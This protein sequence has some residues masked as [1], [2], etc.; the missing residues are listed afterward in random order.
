MAVAVAVAVAVAGA[1]AVAV[2]VAVADRRQRH[3]E[4]TRRQNPTGK[5]R[6]G[7]KEVLNFSLQ[8]QS[9]M[10]IHV[11]RTCSVE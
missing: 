10:A 5:D 11:V 8:T 7:F 2:A 4:R 9:L 6:G 1:V 3:G